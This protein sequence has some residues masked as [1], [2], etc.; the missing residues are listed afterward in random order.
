ML[1]FR[2]RMSS[3]VDKRSS[4]V[5]EEPIQDLTNIESLDLFD[6][7]YLEDVEIQNEENLSLTI[8]RLQ[9]VF[10]NTRFLWMCLSCFHKVILE[11][12]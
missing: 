3:S 7:L 2:S 6:P 1:I 12:S 8:H 4:L 5:Y 10:F 11:L 9:L